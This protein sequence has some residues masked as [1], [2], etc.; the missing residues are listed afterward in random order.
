M[1]RE[2]E[3]QKVDDRTIIDIFEAVGKDYGYKMVKVYIVALTDFKMRWTRVANKDWIELEIA[4]YLRGAPKSVIEDV[5]KR[6]FGKIEGRVQ[7][8]SEETVAYFTSPK[9]AEINGEKYLERIKAKW[10]DGKCK[11][12]DCIWASLVTKGLVKGKPYLSWVD[13]VPNRGCSRHST[14]MDSIAVSKSLDCENITDLTLGL[15]LYHAYIMI[16]EGKKMFGFEVDPIVVQKRLE[17]YPVYKSAKTQLDGW[18]MK[19]V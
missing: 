5:A 9:F 17:E 7:P 1:S 10:T 6:V 4:D 2:A 14:A 12:L 16:D 13:H 11:D 15:V 19:L 3:A 8:Y 18:R